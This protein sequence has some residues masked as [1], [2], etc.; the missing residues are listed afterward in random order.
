M[1]AEDRSRFTDEELAV[2]LINPAAPYS[3]TRIRMAAAIMAAAGVSA[4]KIIWLARQERCESVVGHIARCG[5]AVEPE[6]PFWKALLRE[7]PAKPPSN[8]DALPHISRFVA[9]SGINRSGR[10]HTMQW[11][12]PIP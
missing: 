2:A 3:L 7:L 10:Q 5:N 1:P 11:I 8:P 4:E 6:N 9:F 12:R